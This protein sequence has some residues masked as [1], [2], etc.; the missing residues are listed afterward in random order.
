MADCESKTIKPLLRLTTLT[1][2]WLSAIQM[3]VLPVVLAFDFGGV[4]WWSHYA[5]ALVMVICGVL[6]L[7]TLIDNPLRSLRNHKI[8]VPLLLWLAYT[9]LHCVT[10]DASLVQW[11]SPAI[12]KA[13]QTWLPPLGDEIFLEQPIPLSLAPDFT[14]HAVCFLA[15][16]M[17][18]AWAATQVFVTSSRVNFLLHAISIGAA[19]QAAYGLACLVNPEWSIR[20]ASPNGVES[21]FGSFVNRNNSALYFNFGIA[22]SLGILTSR[23]ADAVDQQIDE[24]DFELSDF[25]VLLNDYRSL[26]AVASLVLCG[27]GVLTCGSRSGL[28]SAFVGVFVAFGVLRG[29]QFLSR[30]I[31]IASVLVMAAAL[32]ILPRGGRGST[33]L[34]RLDEIDLRT[35]QGIADNARWNHWSDSVRTAAAHF[36]AG[37]GLATYAYAYLPYQQQGS[38]SWFHHADNLWLECLVEQGLP[39][40]LFCAVVVW[41]VIRGLRKLNDASDPTDQGLRAAGWFAL[42]V[43]LCSQTFDFGLIVPSNLICCILLFCVVCSKG[44]MVGE[45]TNGFLPSRN[46]KLSYYLKNKILWMRSAGAAFVILLGLLS[47]GTLRDDAIDDTAIRSA[48]MNLKDSFTDQKVLNQNRLILAQRIA[49]RPTASLHNASGD[50]KK[51]LARL[52]TVTSQEFETPEEVVEAYRDTHARRLRSAWR[53]P[54]MDVLQPNAE[55]LETYASAL[56]NYQQCLRS[57]PLASIP[58]AGMVYLDFIHRDKELTRTALGQLEQ[59]FVRSPRQLIELAEW[60]AGGNDYDLAGRYWKRATKLD[61]RNAKFSID[62]VREYPEIRLVDCIDETAEAQR[63]VARL[64]V[65]NASEDEILRRQAPEFLRLASGKL[66]C[67]ECDSLGDEAECLELAGDL[68][69]FLGEADVALEHYAAAAQLDTDNVSLRAKWINR[70]RDAGQDSKALSE[71]QRARTTM[72]NSEFFDLMIQEM[73]REDIQEASENAPADR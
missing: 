72:E 19:V 49:H 40:L 25:L 44:E 37:S 67:R 27:A 63:L 6:A 48:E 56:T 59:L 41:M 46:R 62:F 2:I 1:A 9:L 30:R 47:L 22:C 7:G 29:K 54:A 69:T 18:L 31:V 34:N 32:L 58:R 36:P 38:A 64:L 11:L 5:A 8:L 55:A 57:L 17:P 13:Y 10:F 50:V 73:A 3:L 51:Q 70:L 42:G 20:P 39:G 16:L 35:G 53:E 24:D 12:A 26:V 43:I 23:L 71:A 4:L 65:D 45:E 15:C 21:G 68:H 33:T 52:I 66:Q 14:R 61:Y 60:A 28:L